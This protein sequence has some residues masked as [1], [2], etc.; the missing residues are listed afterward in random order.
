[1]LLRYNN[2]L[3]R[4]TVSMRRYRTVEQHQYTTILNLRL[5][6]FYN[7]FLT[8]E[9]IKYVEKTD[10]YLINKVWNYFNYSF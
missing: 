8:S 3:F 5:D 1:M 6:A 10:I 4:C 7:R 2:F 9:K